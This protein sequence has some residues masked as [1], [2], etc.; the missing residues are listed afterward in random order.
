MGGSVRERRTA[1]VDPFRNAR[2]RS[3][4]IA[5]QGKGGCC[6]DLVECAAVQGAES[7]R[8]SLLRDGMQAVA[9][10]HGRLVYPRVGV[11]RDLDG[12]APRL[13]AD[14]G[15]GHVGAYIEHL[16]AGDDQ[17][18]ARFAADIGKPDIAASHG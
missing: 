12:K 7:L 3:I 6:A 13:G 5:A 14:L 17:H 10:D 8:E 16:V 11:D 2:C 9:V 1:V 18:G 4:A 15:H